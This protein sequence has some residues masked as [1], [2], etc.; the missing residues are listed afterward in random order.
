[1][2]KKVIYTKEQ[3]VEKAYELLKVEGLNSITARN[4]AK[5]LQTSPAPVYGYFSSMDLLKDELIKK[6][7]EQFLTYVANPYTD[8][9]FLNAGMG[10]VIFAREE[11][12]LFRSIFLMTSSYRDIISE[13]K[14]LI[15]EEI[16]KDKRFEKVN[17]DKKNWLY[18]KCW[19]YAHGFATLISMGIHK[20]NSDESI[21]N[22]LLD[23]GIFFS[24][25][26]EK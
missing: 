24:H 11:K 13:F 7:K 16:D 25:V 22:N 12:E 10:F 2:P 3:I 6:A 1:M 14:E 18:E 8:K 4:L 21:K 5:N 17:L 26:L 15:F 19:T 9:P 20:E 23:L